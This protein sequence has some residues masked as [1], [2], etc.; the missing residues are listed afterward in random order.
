MRGLVSIDLG[1]SLQ[2]YFAAM[3][4]LLFLGACLVALASQPVM[5]QTGGADVVI[6]KVFE[7]TGTLRIAISHGE[8]KTEV[9]EAVGGGS[10]KDIVTSSESLHKVIAGL[11]QQGYSLKSTFDGNQGVLSTLVFVKGQ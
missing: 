3:K 8:G 6:V 1:G 11:Y 10:K 5:A 9:V 2:H 4:K 7:M